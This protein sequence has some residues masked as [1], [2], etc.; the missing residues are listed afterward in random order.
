MP[1]R[2]KLHSFKYNDREIKF[3]ITDPEDSI[4]SAILKEEFYEKTELEK[5]KKMCPAGMQMLDIG[6]NI[7]NHTIFFS[8]ALDALSVTVIEPHPVALT[9]LKCNIAINYTQNV[10]TSYLG[11]ALG[12]QVSCGTIGHAYAGNLGSSQV[13]AGSSFPVLPGDVLFTK[14]HFDFVKI[15]VEGGEIG[16]LCGL[17]NVLTRC[18]PW[19]FIEVHDENLDE[20]AKWRG[21]MHYSI[22]WRHKRYKDNENFLLKAD[23]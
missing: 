17:Y 4:Q 22:V 11:I 10:D 23:K 8:L 16:V 5:I 18:K 21:R 19:I 7:G 3:I 6:A 13:V 9:H 12:D 15:D 20:F 1:N 14:Q 2:Q